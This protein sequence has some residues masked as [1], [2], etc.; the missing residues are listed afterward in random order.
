MAIIDDYVAI[1]AELRRKQAETRPGKNTG[2]AGEPA[3]HRMRI[4][5]DGEQLYR[6]LVAREH[7]GTLEQGR[8]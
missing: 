6:R 2:A 7:K 3:Q 5:I 8:G 1:A 4:T